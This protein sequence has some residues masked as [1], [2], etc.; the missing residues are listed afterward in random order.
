[1]TTPSPATKP[2]ANRTAIVTGASAGIGLAIAE[3]LVARGARV[4]V[5]ARR[6]DRLSALAQKLNAEHGHGK[7]VCVAVP[8]DAAAQATIDR[9][10]EAAAQFSGSGGCTDLV[11]INAGRGLSGSVSTSDVSQWEDMVR[12]NLLGA[13][14]LMRTAA[15]RLTAAC[16]VAEGEAGAQGSW[17]NAPR[18]IVLL[19][20]TV[21]RHISPFSSMY[22]STKFA[23]HSLGEALRREIGPKGVRVSVIEPGVV[24]S[25]FQAV[26]GYDPSNFGAF[27]RRIGPVV[28]PDDVARSVEFIVSQPAHIHVADLLIRPTRQEYP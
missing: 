10:F 22:G 26:A 11:V 21:G 7:T 9:M 3:R 4:V 15:Q 8:G 20:S 2:L 18:D 5:N 25:E 14:R 1:M 12:T 13:A 6:A 24:E 23:L 28:Q 17:L 19:G 27:M 16:D